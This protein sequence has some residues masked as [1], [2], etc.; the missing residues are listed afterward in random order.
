MVVSSGTR[1]NVYIDGFNLYHGCFDDPTGGRANWRQYR[2]LD[3]GAYCATV[4]PHYQINR[5]RYFTALVRPTPDNPDCRARQLEYIRALE[6]IP[7]LT[8]H[9]GRFATNVKKRNI[10][11]LRSR[12]A[13]P[14][15]PIQAV[16]VIEEREKASD[17]N[18]GSYLLFDAFRDEYD[19]AVVISNDADLLTPIE[20][21]R[22]EL[23]RR[24]DLVNPRKTCAYDL[25]GK[26]DSYR[27]V[28]KGVLSVCQFPPVMHDAHGT[29][30]KP[31]TW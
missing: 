20:L 30:I 2:W 8:V 31:A 19:T 5:I 24:I 14:M 1:A 16:Y 6:T 3:L 21:V 22:N 23:G 11:D 29:I 27:V 13:A 25:Q 7:T 26:T 12:P 9:R 18:L 10:A 17:V 28:R 15:I 4:F